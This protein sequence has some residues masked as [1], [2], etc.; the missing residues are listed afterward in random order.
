MCHRYRFSWTKQ[1]K[2]FPLLW[3]AMRY[4]FSVVFS[5][6]EGTVIIGPFAFHHVWGPAGA[7]PIVG[8]EMMRRFTLTFD[9]KR[10]CFIWNRTQVSV[11]LGLHPFTEG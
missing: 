10:G 7:V 6:I 3:R 2:P 5:Q 1:R 9:A 11:N 8:M 4:F